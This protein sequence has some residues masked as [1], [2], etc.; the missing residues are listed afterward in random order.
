MCEQI[1]SKRKR[2]THRCMDLLSC[3][4]TG[5]GQELRLRPILLFHPFFSINK[6]EQWHCYPATAS[7]TSSSNLDIRPLRLVNSSEKK[8]EICAVRSIF[9]FPFVLQA[10]NCNW[11]CNTGRQEGERG[12]GP[13]RAESLACGPPN[14]SCV[15]VALAIQP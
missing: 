6:V 3:F 8:I 12:G 13:P 14:A 2:C 11:D 7:S 1:S 15:H 5:E 9:S 4:T 10:C